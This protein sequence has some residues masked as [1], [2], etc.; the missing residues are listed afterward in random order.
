VSTQAT[1]TSGKWWTA[2][3]F[4]EG[5]CHHNNIVQSI[6]HESVPADSAMYLPAPIDLHVHGGGGHDCMD[7]DNA[8]RG[9]LASHARHG[10][11][12]MWNPQFC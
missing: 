10:T 6:T 7:G 3:G 8:L 1:V 2:D 4:V 12:A 9:M 5:V 11:C